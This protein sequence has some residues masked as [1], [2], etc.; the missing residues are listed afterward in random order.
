MV[1]EL[2]RAEAASFHQGPGARPFRYMKQRH[3]LDVVEIGHVKSPEVRR[4]LAR[5]RYAFLILL[6]EDTHLHRR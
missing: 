5:P 6:M 1:L 3:S 2:V 4:R